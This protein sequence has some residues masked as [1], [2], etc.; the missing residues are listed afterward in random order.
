MDVELW[1]LVMVVSDVGVLVL[2]VDEG[3]LVVLGAGELVMSD[4]EVLSTLQGTRRLLGLEL[5]S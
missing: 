5:L 1:V 3:V 4:K 2:V